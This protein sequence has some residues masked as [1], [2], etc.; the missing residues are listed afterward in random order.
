MTIADRISADI[1]RAIVDGLDVSS[2]VMNA[3]TCRYLESEGCISTEY[4]GMYWSFEPSKRGWWFDYSGTQYPVD[5]LD[6]LPIAEFLVLTTDRWLDPLINAAPSGTS[7]TYT[8]EYNIGGTFTIS[9][10]SMTDLAAQIEA[11][12][13][14]VKKL[15]KQT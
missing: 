12:K 14:E 13:A 4:R 6:A 7:G 9:G 2:I 11:I 8:G 3:G 15:A 1:S 10:S 5:I